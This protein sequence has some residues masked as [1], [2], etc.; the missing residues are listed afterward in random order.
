[1]YIGIHVKYRYS[2]PILMKYNLFKHNLGK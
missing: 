2:C 1:M